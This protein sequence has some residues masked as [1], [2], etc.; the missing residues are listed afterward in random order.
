MRATTWER[1][2]ALNIVDFCI[3]KGFAKPYGC[4]YKTCSMWDWFDKNGLLENGFEYHDGASKGVI[5][6]EDLEDWVIKFRL[7]CESSEKDYC[8]REYDNYVAAEEAGL[9]YY[10]ASTEYLCEREG[11]VFYL[12]EKV[13]Q[14]SDVDSRIVEKLEKQYN[15][16]GSS[17][18]VNDLYEEA[19]EMSA[20]E[21]I[22]LLYGDEVLANFIVEHRINDLHC[23]NFGIVGDH[24]VMLDF[25][26][27]G[28]GVWK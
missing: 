10:F 27:Y 20:Y 9:E 24:Y 18:N 5:F 3:N 12:Q 14:D 23:G 11:I 22:M 2:I 7:P 28:S 17:Y 26:G 16:S 1:D 15:D 6:H 25:S 4:E 19:E 8:C 21:R 13:E